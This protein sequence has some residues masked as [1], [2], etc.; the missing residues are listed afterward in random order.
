MNRFA[1]LWVLAFLYAPSLWAEQKQWLVGPDAWV[2]EKAGPSL[3]GYA[4][5]D[6][7]QVGPDLKDPL[8]R[9]VVRNRLVLLLKAGA[10]AT[11]LMAVLQKKYRGEPM[12]F[13]GLDPQTNV[14]QAEVPPSQ[15]EQW[16]SR[17]SGHPLIEA[18]FFEQLLDTQLVPL[19]PELVSGQKPHAWPYRRMGLFNAW[20]QTLGLPEVSIA[21]IDSGFDRNHPELLGRVRTYWNA[22][23]RKRELVGAKDLEIHGTHVA[24][25]A[26]GRAGNTLGAAGACPGCSLVL[27]QASDAAGNL[28]LSSVAN[29]I[30][31]ALFKGAKVINL[32]LGFFPSEAFAGMGELQKRRVKDLF[33]NA[34]QGEV[35]FWRRLFKA[36]ADKGAVVVQAAGNDNFLAALDPMKRA[37]G[38]L[39][40]GA[41]DRNG[42]RASFS[43]YGP[44]V[45]LSAPGVG[46][47]GALPERRFGTRDG[48]SMAAPLVAGVLGLM[49]SAEPELTAE[50][51]ISLILNSAEIQRGQAGQSIGPLVRADLA[52]AA[53]KGRPIQA[54]PAEPSCSPPQ[55]ELEEENRRLKRELAELKEQL[56]RLFILPENQDVAFSKG[57]WISNTSLTNQ[58]REP[59]R[60][61]FQFDGKGGGRIVY[62]EGRGKTCLAS[63]E[64]GFK[65]PELTIQQLEEAH[66]LAMDR[67]YRAYRFRCRNQGIKGAH[68]FLDSQKGLSMP[69]R[70]FRSKLGE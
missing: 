4:P 57:L 53:L 61:F 19:D 13:V 70:L 6:P 18:V 2:A 62:D 42:A 56:S 10:D 64:M 43:N 37:Q 66:C 50:R 41:V 59:V 32:S 46:I 49:F 11:E 68:C 44:E 29:G 69:F 15:A 16:K 23:T 27:I 40:I 20:D 48:T 58:D 33:M 45:N 28:S 51:A 55:K 34:S 24:S 5:I 1:L 67:S 17:F 14:L 38:S 12:K 60:L 26:A 47:F 8:Q 54:Q 9:R 52:L 35:I 36:A 7:R 21:V 3:V 39:V 30:Y 63:L 31:Y 22:S 65:G 25:L